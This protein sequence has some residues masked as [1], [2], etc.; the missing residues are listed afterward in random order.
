[1]RSCRGLAERRQRLR[2]RHLSANVSM[3]RGSDGAVGPRFRCPARVGQRFN[4]SR[5]WGRAGCRCS[6]GGGPRF[7]VSRRPVP[8]SVRIQDTR[9][10]APTPNMSA[11][12]ALAVE[13][14]DSRNTA[15]RPRRRSGIGMPR[16]TWASSWNDVSPMISTEKGFGG[17]STRRRSTD[18]SGRTPRRTARE[19]RSQR[20]TCDPQMR[21]MPCS[22]R[23]VAFA[24]GGNGGNCGV[25]KWGK[26]DPRID[27]R[28][29]MSGMWRS[30]ATDVDP[31]RFAS[32]LG[33]SRRGPAPRSDFGRTTTTSTI[34][35]EVAC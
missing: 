24:E 6:G 7:D 13:A 30:D 27:R 31:C 2:G 22:R 8:R 9:R 3:F 23:R 15:G 10:G 19:G 17:S 33:M 18:P 1:V 4:V 26:E 11:D 12:R 28:G 32:V 16:E 25:A 20:R 14:G 35:S 21:D 29:A 5:R 34:P